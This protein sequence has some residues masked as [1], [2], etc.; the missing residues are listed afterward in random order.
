MAQ[1]PLEQEGV[2]EEAHGDGC[3]G[4]VVALRPVREENE[5]G[6]REEGLTVSIEMDDIEWT[7]AQIGRAHV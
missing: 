4:E 1:L 6:E 3:G 5:R 2:L 7:E